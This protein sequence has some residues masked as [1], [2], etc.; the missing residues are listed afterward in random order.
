MNKKFNIL[1]A[2]LNW[3]TFSGTNGAGIN[4]SAYNLTPN[5]KRQLE[6][7]DKAHHFNTYASDIISVHRKAG[8]LRPD[9][10]VYFFA[11]DCI[12]NL[13]RDM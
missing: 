12:L 9:E 10:S 8:D 6:E 2:W 11:Q 4:I 5:E 3:G 13:S 7:G 1:G